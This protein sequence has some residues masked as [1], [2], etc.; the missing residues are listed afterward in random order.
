MVLGQEGPSL[1]HVLRDLA[2]LV[3]TS[4]P[5]DST[6]VMKSYDRSAQSRVMKT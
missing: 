1:G 3:V 6:D 2:A 5:D 4:P